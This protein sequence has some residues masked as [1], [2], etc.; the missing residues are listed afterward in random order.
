MA[1]EKNLSD[2][3]TQGKY[4][5]TEAVA[6][7]TCRSISYGFNANGFVVVVVVGYT[8]RRLT[9]RERKSKRHAKVARKRPRPCRDDGFFRQSAEK[10]N[11]NIVRRAS[12]MN[13]R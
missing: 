2:R 1:Y 5:F 3:G 13:S 10:K 8:A 12:R 6:R 11:E 7:V 4:A 9:F